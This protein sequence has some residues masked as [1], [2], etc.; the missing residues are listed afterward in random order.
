MLI[1]NGV[2]VTMLDENFSPAISGAFYIVGKIFEKTLDS[3]LKF[4]CMI[5]LEIM[6]C[7]NLMFRS[8]NLQRFSQPFSDF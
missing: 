8:E 1:K 5:F 6:F 4:R 7:E 3:H 2:S